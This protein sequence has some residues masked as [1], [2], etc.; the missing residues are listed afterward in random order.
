MKKLGAILIVDDDELVLEALR[1]TFL[2][3]YEI[4]LAISGEE[5]L[6]MVSSDKELDTV[7]LDIKM[8]KMDGLET[9]AAIR[10]INHDIPVI[11]HTGYPGDYSE[12][13]IDRKHR[14][15][16]YVGKNERPERLMR[17]VRNAVSFHRLRTRGADMIAFAREHYGMV[18][19]SRAMRKVYETI[20]KVSPTD[21]KVMILGPTGSGKELVARAIHR[22]SR[23]SDKVLFI[24][25]CNHKAPDLVESELFGHRRGSFTGAVE[26]RVGMFE[27]ANGGTM[28]L[29]EIGNLDI[30]TQGKLLRVLET[31]EMQRIGSPESITVDVRLICATNSSLEEMVA[32]KTFREDLYYRLKGIKVTLEPL[33]RR[34]EDIPDLIDYFVDNYCRRTDNTPKVLADD[35]RNLLIEYDWPGNVRQL[36]DTVQSLIDLSP[37]HL[38]TRKEVSDYLSFDGVDGD[39]VGSYHERVREYKRLLMCQALSRHNDIVAPAARELGLDPSNM[40]KMLKDL[41][42]DQD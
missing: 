37:S 30:T 41:D 26:D 1:Q 40:R 2:D 15:F 27:Y 9:A 42:L 38:I 3:D 32:E 5:A 11:F 24:F 6:E 16:D 14:P 31:G 35:A 18:G 20:E 36:L 10:E 33:K 12:A 7:I 19:R 8:A 39:H 23:R 13:E 25:N 22:R 4:T 17:S 21:N 29:D 34:R 28:F